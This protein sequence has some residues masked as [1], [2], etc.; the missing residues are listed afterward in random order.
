MKDKLDETICSTLKADKETPARLASLSDNQ[1]ADF[2]KLA[3]LKSSLQKPSVDEIRKDVQ[4]KNPLSVANP[5][6]SLRSLKWVLCQDDSKYQRQVEKMA[7]DSSIYYPANQ[8]R[9]T[10]LDSL[11][12]ALGKRLPEGK[13]INPTTKKS[14][15]DSP[16]LAI[17]DANSLPVSVILNKEKFAKDV[18]PRSLFA[19]SDGEIKITHP[20]FW[21]LISSQNITTA[22]GQQVLFS[23]T[24]K[25]GD[26]KQIT[27]DR[28]AF[29]GELEN[30]KESKR[31]L[32]SKLVTLQS[33][34]LP[35]MSPE[36]LK[37][38]TD[39][40]GADKPVSQLFEVN[41][42]PSASK[43][44]K[45]D[46]PNATPTPAPPK[47]DLTR[48]L[49]DKLK[50]NGS[51]E[52]LLSRA[53]ARDHVFAYFKDALTAFKRNKGIDSTAGWLRENKEFTAWIYNEFA[54]EIIKKPV[55][56]T[57]CL[58][59]M[60]E[61]AFN[62]EKSGFAPD[63]IKSVFN[64]STYAPAAEVLDKIFDAQSKRTAQITNSEESIKTAQD[65]IDKFTRPDKHIRFIA[66]S[67]GT[68]IVGFSIQ[69]A[70]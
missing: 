15:L 9:Q 14:A 32:E 21:A 52:V 3:D 12:E 54:A 44:K 69:N 2:P 30:A 61:K 60:N 34:P 22:D 65:E 40:L 39:W 6:D 16:F 10:A 28:I 56:F 26:L 35:E 1:L 47:N 20:V 7:P 25:P 43:P 33:S 51:L 49:R 64:L 11:L 70:P 18:L 53:G 13:L 46:L 58:K 57:S 66:K 55:S 19:F 24:M 29:T 59:S 45:S 8:N 48:Y 68:E 38:V 62:S 23:Y 41:G 50:D 27:S 42:K 67:F 17:L 36:N 37:L 5:G 31:R 63:E 4:E